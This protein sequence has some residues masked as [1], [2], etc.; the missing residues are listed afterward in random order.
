[1]YLDF[2]SYTRY[3][4][5]NLPPVKKSTPEHVMSEVKNKGFFI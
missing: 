1:M 3:K 4:I 5:F 2:Y